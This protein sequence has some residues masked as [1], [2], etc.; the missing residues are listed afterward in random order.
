MRWIW[1]ITWINR[2]FF[3]FNLYYPFQ[4]FHC[5]V[6]FNHYHIGWHSRTLNISSDFCL[7]QILDSLLVVKSK[8]GDKTCQ[9][10][11]GGLLRWNQPPLQV[12]KS[13]VVLRKSF[14][15]SNGSSYHFQLRFF[16]DSFEGPRKVEITSLGVLMFFWSEQLLPPLPCIP[17]PLLIV[18]VGN[19]LILCQFHWR[20]LK[21][22]H[23]IHFS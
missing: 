17:P 6:I 15:H 9:N 18:V 7:L 3:S 4:Y 11:S 13:P 2:Y 5:S 8:I 23:E 16:S 19:V 21:K 22:S 12:S 1:L 20:D 10:H 14:S